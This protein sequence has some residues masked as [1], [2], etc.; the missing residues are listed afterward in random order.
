[1]KPVSD[2]VEALDHEERAASLIGE[3]A[4]GVAA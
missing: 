2:L 1:M 3:C 4:L